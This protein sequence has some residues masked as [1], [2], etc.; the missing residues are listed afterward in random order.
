MLIN[1][2][3]IKNLSKCRTSNKFFFKYLM[4]WYVPISNSEKKNNI[5]FLRKHFKMICEL[6]NRY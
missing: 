2:F 5:Y 1:Q 4:V 3:Y 6:I